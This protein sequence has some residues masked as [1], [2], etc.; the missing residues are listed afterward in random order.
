MSKKQE[1]STDTMERKLP[2][3][4][5]AEWASSAHRERIVDPKK[6]KAFVQDALNEAWDRIP[7]CAKMILTYCDLDVLHLVNGADSYEESEDKPPIECSSRYGRVIISGTKVFIN[8]ACFDQTDV[9]RVDLMWVIAHEFAHMFMGVM[10]MWAY[11]GL[12]AIVEGGHESRALKSYPLIADSAL[13]AVILQGTINFGFPS[14]FSGDGYREYMADTYALVWGFKPATV[15]YYDQDCREV[16]S[17]S[18]PRPAT[19]VE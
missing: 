6:T 14:A 2:K 12:E 9:G 4:P 17:R 15:K 18:W 8:V 13:M 10:Q 16:S 19:T 3:A 11:F 7:P 5:K 1:A